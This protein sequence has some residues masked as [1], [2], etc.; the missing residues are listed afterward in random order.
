MLPGHNGLIKQ[1]KVTQDTLQYMFVCWLSSKVNYVD[2]LKLDNLKT[3]LNK[4]KLSKCLK[5]KFRFNFT[6]SM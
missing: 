3:I 1:N 4:N 2:N 5:N 6:K